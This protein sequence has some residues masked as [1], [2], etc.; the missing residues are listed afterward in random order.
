MNYLTIF[1]S[2]YPTWL[3]YLVT[4]LV[5]IGIFSGRF[6]FARYVALAVDIF[7]NVFTGGKV[8]VTISARS[9]IAAAKGKKWGIYMSKFLDL[10]DKGHCQKALQGD[11]DRARIVLTTLT[12][13]D[14][15]NNQ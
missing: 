9:E 1:L 14:K 15:R 6:T 3:G 2:N 11:I 7:W 4:L 8:G 5:F 10:L 13:Y 12:P